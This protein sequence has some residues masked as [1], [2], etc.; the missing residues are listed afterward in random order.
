MPQPQAVIDR[1]VALAATGLSRST[2]AEEVGLS[3]SLVIGVLWRRGIGKP[4]GTLHTTKPARP[5]GIGAGDRRPVKATVTGAPV[6]TIKRRNGGNDPAATKKAAVPIYLILET[7]RSTARNSKIR[8]F[9]N[10]PV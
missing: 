10:F 9:T 3:R 5:R 1:I 7:S 8:I 6:P 4:E 2:I